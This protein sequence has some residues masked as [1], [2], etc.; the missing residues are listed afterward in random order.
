MV[1]SFFKKPP[2]KM[3]ARPPATPRAPEAQENAGRKT[4]GRDGV[5]AESVSQNAV[6]EAPTEKGASPTDSYLDFVFSES[7]PDFHVEAE[8]DPI[9]AR[10]RGANS[11]FRPRGALMVN[12]V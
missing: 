9:G 8:I 7:S 3:V 6:K 2:E 11:P 4:G 10:K 12:V 5:S 1:F